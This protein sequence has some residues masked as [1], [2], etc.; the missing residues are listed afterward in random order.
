ML[1]L[2]FDCGMCTSHDGGREGSGKDKSRGE[3]AYDIDHGCFASD[4]SALVSI[5]FA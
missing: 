5:S 3:G 4:I 1:L 2:I